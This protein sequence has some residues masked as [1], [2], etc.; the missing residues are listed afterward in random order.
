MPPDR[1]AALSGNAASRN[2]DPDAWVSGGHEKFETPTKVVSDA[3]SHGE[4]RV[5]PA[6][7]SQEDHHVSGNLSQ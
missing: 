5:S 7:P 1:D 4:G 2:D 6:L 3:A